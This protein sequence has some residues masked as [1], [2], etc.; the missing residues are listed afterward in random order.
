MTVGDIIAARHIEEVLHFTTN[1]GITGMIASGHALSRK[2]LPAEE[3][4]EHVYQYNCE[5]RSRD[6]NWHDYINLSITTVNRN[7]FG[8]S[9]GKWHRAEDGWWC[10][11]SFVPEIMTH[12]RVVFTTTNNMYSGVERQSGPDGLER[13]FVPRIC[14]WS[15]KFVSRPSACLPNQPTC[16]QA[17]VLY[18][19]KLSLEYL[20]R[21]YVETPNNAAALESIL[22]LYSLDVSVFERP[23]LF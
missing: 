10:I 19:G 11:A 20:K 18:P 16:E 2:R 12:D 14:Q 5:D 17:E 9:K 3:H 22:G 1:R 4:L 15:G 21:L 23:E 6:A 8:I 13:L 7:L